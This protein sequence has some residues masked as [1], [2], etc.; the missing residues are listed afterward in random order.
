MPR[1]WNRRPGKRRPLP[2]GGKRRLSSRGWVDPFP[3]VQGS[4]PEKMVLAGL[5][6]RG[7]YFEHTPQTNSVGS[8]VPSDWEPDFWFPQYRIW[9]E[10]NGL[11]FH[12][13][14]NA[15]QMDAVRYATLEAAGVKVV[16]WWDFDILVRLPDLFAEV[17]EFNN[18]DPSKQVG[19]RLTPGLPFYEGGDGIDHLKGLRTANRNRARPRFFTYR[20]RSARL[21]V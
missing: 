12:T 14:G 10:V 13:L 19:Y 9:L 6:A 18:V 21:G 1:R 8:G 3:A 17:P 5:V 2:K 11:Y 15:Q 4:K 16:V 20:V 7:I